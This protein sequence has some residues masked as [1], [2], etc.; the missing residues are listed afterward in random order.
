MYNKGKRRQ[1]SIMLRWVQISTDNLLKSHRQGNM[2][3]HTYRNS[4]ASAGSHPTCSVWTTAGETDQALMAKESFVQF[5]HTSDVL[6]ELL[7]IK[8]ISS[9]HIGRGLLLKWLEVGEMWSSTEQVLSKEGIK[10][11]FIIVPIDLALS[12]SG[13]MEVSQM[14]SSTK[15]VQVILIYAFLAF[16]RCHI[17]GQK[18]KV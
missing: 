12:W 8:I 9:N 16:F 11:T 1:T 7:L 6:C 14:Q 4:H 15:Y 17:T 3:T 18:M 2:W 10:H 13:W 5:S